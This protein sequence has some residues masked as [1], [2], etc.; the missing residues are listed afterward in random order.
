MDL[1]YLRNQIDDE[2][3]GAENYNQKA[4]ECPEYSDTFKAMAKQ[5]LSHADNLMKILNTIIDQAK[6]LSSIAKE[7]YKATED[8]L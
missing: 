6:E 8:I 7:R 2:L 3:S 5:E 4:E 1:N